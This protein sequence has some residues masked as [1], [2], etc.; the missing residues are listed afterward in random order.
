MA[1]FVDGKRRMRI[2]LV[3]SGHR[4]WAGTARE[5]MTRFQEDEVNRA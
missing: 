5:S 4:K 3:V 2:I 1:D